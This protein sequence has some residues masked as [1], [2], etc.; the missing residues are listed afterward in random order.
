MDVINPA[1]DTRISQVPDTTAEEV[2]M[3]VEA[4]TRAN[5]AREKAAEHQRT[6]WQ[7]VFPIAVA[8]RYASAASDLARANASYEKA[9]AASA[10]RRC[11]EE[12]VQG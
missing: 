5:D 10:A 6:S 11:T 3:A 7:V 4:A 9:S 1:R 12:G 8:A 2:G